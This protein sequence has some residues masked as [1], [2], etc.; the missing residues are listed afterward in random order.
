MTCKQMGGPCD[1][2]MQADTAEEMMK[3]GG[4]HV[5]EMAATGDEPHKQVL[6]MMEETGKDPEKNKAW[7]DTFT[8]DFA[9]L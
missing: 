7:M 4:D 8:A 2:S 3:M 6:M 1:F 9:A 5:R